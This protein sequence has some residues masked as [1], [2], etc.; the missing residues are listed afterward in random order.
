MS[1]SN[2]KELSSGADAIGWNS[3]PKKKKKS[4]PNNNYLTQ[5]LNKNNKNIYNGDCILVKKLFYQQKAK[6]SCVIVEGKAKFFVS[7]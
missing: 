4:N 2:D 3:L 6:K 1:W 5:K 7:Y